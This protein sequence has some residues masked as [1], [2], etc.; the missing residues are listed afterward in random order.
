MAK[1]RL[2]T[3]LVERGLATS[4]QKA[5]ALILA[6][7]VLVN[8][9][10]AEKVGVK[11]PADVEIRLR[12]GQSPFVGRGGEKIAPAFDA[13]QIE[14]QDIVA[15]DIGASTGGFTDCMLQRGVSRVYAV[16]V[17][18][19]QLDFSLRQDDRVVVLER[20]NARY[21]SEDLFPEKPVLA[22]VDVSFISVRKLLASITH[23]LSENADLV[24][25]VKPQFELE[26]E[27]VGK[28][29][30]VHDEKLHERAIQL[31][32]DVASELA[33]TREGLVASTLRGQ[34]KG[35]QEYFL[36]VRRRV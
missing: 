10:P 12:R 5:Q 19:N 35:N 23:V 36:H 24:I 21:L 33:F 18:Y 13:F 26:P 7:Q 3:L 31:V 1:Q 14:L 25:L 16:D 22:T 11:F 6:G 20:T 2:D 9:E 4:R 34:K 8:D 15:V 30:V 27:Y 29:G 32:T 28:G 17:G